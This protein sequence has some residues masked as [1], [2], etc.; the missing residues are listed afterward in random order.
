MQNEI[1][2]AI[3]FLNNELVEVF[4]LLQ[5]CR[6]F[7]KVDSNRSVTLMHWVVDFDSSGIQNTQ[8]KKRIKAFKR[9]C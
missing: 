1:A 4:L 3:R 6:H 8:F 5:F 2:L 7:E 9:T